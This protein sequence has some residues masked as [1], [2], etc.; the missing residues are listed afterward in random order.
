M[1]YI[2]DMLAWVHQAIAGERE[3][4]ES[5]FGIKHDGRMVG[6]V[7]AFHEKM[8]EEELRIRELMDEAVKRLCVPLQV[9]QSLANT[10]PS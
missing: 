9:G 4:L 10:G 5:L 2:G 1:R 3:F 7:R 8:S 6:S